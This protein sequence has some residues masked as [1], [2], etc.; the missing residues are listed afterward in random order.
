VQLRHEVVLQALEPGANKS[1]LA[2]E[3]G[4]SRQN[5]YKWLERFRFDG[6][7]GLEERSRR[8]HKLPDRTPGE[9][10]LQVLELRN[11]HPGWGPKKLHVVLGRRLKKL[12]IK[13]P[14]P[15]TIA[16]I[17]SRAGAISRKRRPPHRLT[18]PH[19]P[20]PPAVSPNDLWTV[21]FKGWWRTDDGARCEP[22]TVRDAFTRYVLCLRVLESTSLEP[23]KREFE[24]LFSVYGLPKGIL[25]DNG[26]P[27]AS[28]TAPAGLT[29]LSAWWVSLG[30]TVY[31][32]RPAHP[33]DNGAHERMHLDVSDNLQKRGAP[34]LQAQQLECDVWRKKF[35]EVRP[36]E[37][38]G[39]KTPSELYKRSPRRP[40]RVKAAQYPA[41]A[42]LR[43]V[44]SHGGI[45][46]NG[47]S[48]GISRA[49]RGHTVAVVPLAG[50]SAAQVMFHSL[51][52]GQFDTLC[53]TRL[54][55]IK[56][57]PELIAA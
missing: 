51:V 6:V 48:V 3:Y 8:P 43:R 4:V 17:L 21:D 32:S 20:A 18:Q 42:E 47:R 24:R 54:E 41:N 29:A 31:R 55:P 33:E 49:L 57:T 7:A 34:T 10:V 37:A 40:E 45:S 5:V 1:A 46:W 35:N 22:L 56:P 36:H 50:G 25:S 15:R 16:R 30:I 2:R 39:M 12:R 9:V 52:L 13:V 38:L 53:G 26:G 19:N 11:A 28:I 23:V 44:V 14:S 27:F